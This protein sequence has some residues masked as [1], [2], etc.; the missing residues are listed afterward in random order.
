MRTGLQDTSNVCMY[1]SNSSIFTR[2]SILDIFIICQWLWCIFGLDLSWVVFLGYLHSCWNFTVSPEQHLVYLRRWKV[3]TV[4]RYLQ[5]A[6]FCTS[7]EQ[8]LHAAEPSPSL[9]APAIQVC[10]FR[11]HVCSIAFALQLTFTSAAYNT[12]KYYIDNELCHHCFLSSTYTWVS[13]GINTCK[14]V[15]VCLLCKCV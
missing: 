4:F 5:I 9:C 14:K 12:C 1:A 13:L 2:F 11:D 3:F 15:W 10:N 6:G 7:R 8:A